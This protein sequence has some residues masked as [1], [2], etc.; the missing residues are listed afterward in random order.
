MNVLPVSELRRLPV[1]ELRALMPIKVTADG[2]LLGILAK[3]NDVVVLG[4]LALGAQKRLVALGQRFRQLS[5]D[6]D[7]RPDYAPVV[8]E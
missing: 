6:K 3:P 7:V 1:G 8:E 4:G 2:E 5:G